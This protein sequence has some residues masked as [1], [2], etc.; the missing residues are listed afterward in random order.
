MMSMDEKLLRRHLTVGIYDDDAE[1]LWQELK[2]YAAELDLL[3]SELQR[4]FRERFI[5]TAED[6]GLSRYEELFGPDRTG[7]SAESRREMLLLR[8]NLGNGDFTLG[9]L[10]RALDSLGLDCVISEFPAIGRLNVTAVTDYS[11]AR[12]AWIRREVA[13]LIPPGIEF[14]L[15]FNTMTWTQWDALDRTFAAIDAENSTWHDI[16]ERTDTQ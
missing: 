8:M 10:Q 13:K 11:P 2:A 1:A 3:N 12:Q 6:E 7:E 5:T 15:T 14:Q 4:I 9:G 16:D